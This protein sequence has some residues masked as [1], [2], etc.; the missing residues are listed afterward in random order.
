MESV[1]HAEAVLSELQDSMLPVEVG[2]AE[3]RAGIAEV[4]EMIAGLRS[5]ARDFMRGLGR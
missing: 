1:D 5:G 3:V 4:R 2:D